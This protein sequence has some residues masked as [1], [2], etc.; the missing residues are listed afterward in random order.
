MKYILLLSFILLSGCAQMLPAHSEKLAD[1]EYRV[2]SIGNVF[3][4][5]DT[6][7]NNIE[8]KA[9]K[10]CP[11]GYSF[12]ETGGLTIDNQQTSAQGIPITVQSKLYTRFIICD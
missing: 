9:E 4:K 1:G 7:Q 12:Q 6:L 8:K 5:Q 3:A 2:T 11:E 10:L